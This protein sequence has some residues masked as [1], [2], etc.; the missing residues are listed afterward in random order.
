MEAII[1]VCIGFLLFMIMAFIMYV[2]GYKKEAV[3][4]RNSSFYVV[5]GYIYLV[6]II[7]FMPIN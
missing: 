3:I 4:I 6:F 5:L 7:G 1:S 2:N